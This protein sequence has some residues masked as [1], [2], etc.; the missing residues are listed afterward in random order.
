MEGFKAVLF[1]TRMNVFNQTFAP[2]GGAI[3]GSVYGFIWDDATCGRKS[4]DIMSYY[5]RYLR[6][7]KEKKHVVLWLDN[8]SSQNKNW[9]LF[10]VMILLVNSALVQTNVVEFKFFEPGHTFM[11]ADS[12]HHS[13]ERRMKAA[14]R[15]HVL[16]TD[17]FFECVNT[18][19]QNAV[20]VRMDPADFCF[21]ELECKQPTKKRPRPLLNTVKY[22]QF[23]RGSYDFIYG[24]DFSGQIATCNLFTRD[25]LRTIKSPNFDFAE[26]LH[27]RST[28]CGIESTESTRLQA[29][30]EKNVPL[31]PPEK[32]MFWY[33]LPER[34][35]N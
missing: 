24:E 34:T 27:Y 30:K 1:T 8:C 14:E 20:A 21:C 11:S 19:Q 12:F 10:L 4:E 23:V 18:A 17:D 32:K 7:E 31:L 3:N 16:T 13:V 15:G 26:K 29:I 2:V 6:M 35:S 28:P 22:V 5:I 33:T 25:Q 9:T